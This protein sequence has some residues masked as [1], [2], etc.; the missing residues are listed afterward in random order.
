MKRDARYAQWLQVAQELEHLHHTAYGPGGFLESAR[1][2]PFKPTPLEAAAWLRK[3]CA[4][5]WW[6]WWDKT[7]LWAQANWPLRSM[8]RMVSEGNWDMSEEGRAFI[9]QV[10]ALQARIAKINDGTPFNP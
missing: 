7:T 2:R 5:G 8:L 4:V 3:K 9:S 6:Y 1:Q 10:M